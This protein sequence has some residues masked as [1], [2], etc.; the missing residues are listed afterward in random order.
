MSPCGFSGIG[1]VD[2]GRTPIDATK[3]QTPKRQQKPESA[4]IKNLKDDIDEL[5]RNLRNANSRSEVKRINKQIAQKKKMLQAAKKGIAF[6][7][8]PKLKR[9]GAVGVPNFIR[10]FEPV[11]PRD[12]V[13][14]YFVSGGRVSRQSI[15]DVILEGE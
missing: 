15:E 4:E 1:A 13:L 2:L 5:N 8:K 12:K 7:E 11:M 14:H 9:V 3:K 10:T 6:T